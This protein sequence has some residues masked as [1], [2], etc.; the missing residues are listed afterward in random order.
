MGAADAEW[1]INGGRAMV[2]TRHASVAPVDPACAG[3]AAPPLI[4]LRGAND[5]YFTDCALH[6]LRRWP[7]TRIRLSRLTFDR[8]SIA[9]C[10]PP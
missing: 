10:P 3:N 1:M 9:A 6:E 4:G 5:G 2:M 7:A 8:R